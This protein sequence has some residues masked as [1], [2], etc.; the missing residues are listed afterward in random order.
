MPALAVRER[1]PLRHTI[2][3]TTPSGSR[4]R[5]AL[6]ERKA[7]NVPAN[8]E[9]SD[10]VPGGYEEFSATLPRKPGRD[11]ADLERLSDVEIFCGLE[12]VGEYRLEAAPRSSGEE[13]SISPEAVGWQAH[14]QDNKTAAEIYVDRDLSHWGAM[15]ST[16]RAS[17]LATY[18][19]ITDAS[20]EL[21]TSGTPAMNFQAQFS[22]TSRPMASAEY[23]AGL[24]YIG[25]I[26]LGATISG[27]TPTS[28]M[29]VQ[30]VLETAVNDTADASGDLEAATIS[31][32]YSATTST[33]RGARILFAWNAAA[34]A[35]NLE[36]NMY[37]RPVVYGTHGLTKRGSGADDGYY[38]SD[39]VANAISRWAPLLNFTTGADGSIKP[40]AFIIPQLEFRDPTTVAEIVKAA[41]R[42]HLRDW[43]VWN[44][45]TFY[46]ADRGD[47]ARYWRARVAPSGLEET[48]PQVDRLWNGVL[49]RYRDV[50][51]SEKTVGPT[52]SGAGTESASLL[53]TDPLNPAN[54]LG[55]RRWTML[56]MGI[57]ST[58]AGATEV[59]RRF[60][61]ES[62]ALDSSG[63]ATITGHVQD[64]KG[65]WHPYSHIR[66]GDY[67]SFLGASD[68]S[69][70][71]I[72]KSTKSLSSH[73]CS[74]DLDA[75]PQG[76]DALL[77][78]LGVG[79]VQFGLG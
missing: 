30:I 22:D 39:V 36:F 26:Y 68:P 58:A 21:T 16:S 6:D 18:T 23:N 45:R 1:P 32:T 59:G 14:L 57:V 4:H 54:Q 42:F 60:L 75:P 5:W 74:L 33:R 15:N 25:S 46:Y 35:A 64:D 7:E 70:R 37:A 66:S 20:T 43:A 63:K 3:I 38:A 65:I 34:T 79:L 44:D 77:E 11:Y 13:M 12:K 19:N 9:W 24:A 78:R 48:G 53:D 10:I 61:E 71:R 56:D 17:L 41:N 52:G 47:G 73:T 76:M 49:V 40:S 8:V 50:D 69:P 28:S 51:G 55:I 29:I 62:K 72:V 67:I 27:Y 2:R 31:S